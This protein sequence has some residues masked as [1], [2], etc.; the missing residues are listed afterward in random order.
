MT[1]QEII[2]PVAPIKTT[3]LSSRLSKGSE[4]SLLQLLNMH[5]AVDRSQLMLIQEA[6]MSIFLSSELS[7]IILVVENAYGGGIYYRN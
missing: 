4:Q 2:Q 6:I 7:D 5:P 3:G 1:F